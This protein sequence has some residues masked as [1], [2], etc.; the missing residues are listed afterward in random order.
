MPDVVLVQARIASNFPT[1]IDIVDMHE[2]VTPTANSPI[3]T[4]S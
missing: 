4:A 1:V 2:D 3:G